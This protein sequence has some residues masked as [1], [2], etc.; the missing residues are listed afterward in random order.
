MPRMKVTATID[1]ELIKW[2]DGEVEKRRFRNRSH[3]LEYA[4]AKLKESE[5]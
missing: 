2:L 4:V 3:A 5:P 1:D